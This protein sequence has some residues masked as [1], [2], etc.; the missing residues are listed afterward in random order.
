MYRILLSFVVTTFL[1]INTFGEP[2]MAE[3]KLTDGMYA[4]FVTNKGDINITQ[5][6]GTMTVGFIDSVREDVSLTTLDTSA[7]DIIGSDVILI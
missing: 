1:L 6:T 3:T 2:V 5:Q 7:G 4:K